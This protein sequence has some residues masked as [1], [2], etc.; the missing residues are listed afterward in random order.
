MTAIVSRRI[1]MPCGSRA[2]F[3]VVAV[4]IAVQVFVACG[5]SPPPLDDVD[6][7]WCVNNPMATIKAGGSIGL[8]PS[9]FVQRTAEV[10]QAVVDGDWARAVALNRRWHALESTENEANPHPG[11]GAM[12]AW[13]TDSAED[14]ANACRMAIERAGAR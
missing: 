12:L 2:N 9:K 11:M 13:E 4:A 6:R 14:F 5:S 10:D 8:R 7:A 1:P 3:R